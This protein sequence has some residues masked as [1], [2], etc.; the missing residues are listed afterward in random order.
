MKKYIS[1]SRIQLENNFTQNKTYTMFQNGG[2]EKKENG[3]KIQET[4]FMWI[5]FG[6]SKQMKR[7]ES[8]GRLSP[9]FEINNYL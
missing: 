4:Y 6:D 7:K 3:E 1:F 8:G 9:N 5:T 2:N